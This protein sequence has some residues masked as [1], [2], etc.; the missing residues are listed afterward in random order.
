MKGKLLAFVTI[1]SIGGLSSTVGVATFWYGS[2]LVGE[3][4][5]S[6]PMIVIGP[7]FAILFVYTCYVYTYLGTRALAYMLAIYAIGFAITFLLVVL[8][9]SADGFKVWLF[10]VLLGLSI[11][12]IAA[13]VS[14]VVVTTMRGRHARA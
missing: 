5:A 11:T 14:S 4:W 7:I 3:S 9:A 1:L 12:E 2:G 10:P 6:L 8:G 13:I